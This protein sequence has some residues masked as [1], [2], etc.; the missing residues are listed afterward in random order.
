MPLARHYKVSEIKQKLLH[1]AQTSVYAVEILTK[2]N[3]NNF[4]GV[5]LPKDQEA[6]NLACCEPSLP[7]SSLA[8]HEVT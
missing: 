7:G 5:N 8:T 4:V 3:I 2:R 6:I 1:P